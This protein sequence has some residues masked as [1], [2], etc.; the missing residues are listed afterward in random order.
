MVRVKDFL[1]GIVSGGVV[2]ILEGIFNIIFGVLDFI[3]GLLPF[4]DMSF[5]S[6][7][8]QSA[9][10]IIKSLAYF[11]PFDTIYDIL[12]LI[13]CIMMF[14]VVVAIIKTIWQLLPLV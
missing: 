14:R 6:A 7:S 5:S 12:G 1:V 13:F 3:I 2:M 11:L 8:L 4:S 9:L 10:D